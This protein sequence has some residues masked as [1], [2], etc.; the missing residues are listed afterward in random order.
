MDTALEDSVRQTRLPKPLVISLEASTPI[1]LPSDSD[2]TGGL[3]LQPGDLL[4]HAP[5]P[6]HIPF[7]VQNAL[8]TAGS[9]I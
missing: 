3:S 1:Y 7:A 9:S 6:L 5:G 4:S 8:P 2:D